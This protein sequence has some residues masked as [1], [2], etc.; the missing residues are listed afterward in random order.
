MSR[1]KLKGAVAVGSGNL[2]SRGA[3]LKK[4]LTP[5]IL[6]K[7]RKAARPRMNNTVE[8]GSGTSPAEYEIEYVTVPG[9]YW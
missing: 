2:D 7:P 6:L 8:E 9:G 5:N 1:S 3:H 4:Y